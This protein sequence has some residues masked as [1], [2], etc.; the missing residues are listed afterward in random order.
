MEGTSGL[1]SANVRW[2]KRA[3]RAVGSSWVGGGGKAGGGAATTPPPPPNPAP[4]TELPPAL[5]PTP[6]PPPPKL[7]GACWKFKF[8][9]T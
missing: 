4:P 3:V 7:R 9:I 2:L 8:A 1:R 6:T 5:P